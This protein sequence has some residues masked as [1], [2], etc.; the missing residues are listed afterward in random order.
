MATKLTIER[1][2]GNVP[3]SLAGEDHISGFMIYM[4]S[5]QV[6]E[7]F[8]SE[9]IQTLSTIEAAE[10]AGITAAGAWLV[11]VLHYHLSEVYRVNPAVSLYVGIF[12]EPSSSASV[13]FREI[14]TMQNYAGG[15]LRQIA[16]WGG[17]RAL[18][19]AADDITTIQ[20][21]ADTLANED[22]ELIVLYA[23]KVTNVTSLSDKV[24]GGN[25]SR[26]SVVIGQAGSGTG[27]ELYDGG[28]GASVSCLGTVLGLVSKA[29][30]HQCIGWVR[31]FPTGINIPAFSDGTEYR[32]V[33]KALIEKLD[34]ARYLFPVTKTGQ[35]GSYMNDSHNMDSAISDYASI[36]SVRTMDKAVRGIRTYMI[37]ELGSNVY[38]DPETGKLASYTVSHLETVANKPL[39]D[40]EKAG[41]LSGYKAIIDPDQ[42]V[43]STS[44]VEILI[45]NVASPV[46]RH[47][48]I[49]IG[50]YKSIN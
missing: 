8:K 41:E 18:G 48:A 28:D 27:K 13:T 2:N 43:A 10:A 45:K 38:V 26:V 34:A 5:T 33:D 16:V 12:A 3:K 22:A 35:S 21:I 9:P 36:E 40:M 17:N 15:K 11:K 20:G 23:P 32:S 7:S 25:K 19:A 44:R 37:P 39:E 42:D 6:P 46:M 1:T 24:A 31:E 14:K 30:V 29:K 4:P 47:I 49:K 50:F